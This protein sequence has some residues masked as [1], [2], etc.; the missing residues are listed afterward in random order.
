[1]HE[2]GFSF[3]GDLVDGAVVGG[4]VEYLFLLVALDHAG[5]LSNKISED[6]L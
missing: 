3:L 5:N 1:M 2:V 6:L 4:G